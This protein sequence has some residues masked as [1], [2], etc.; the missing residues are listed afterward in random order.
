MIS[1]EA[2]RLYEQIEKPI[3][4]NRPLGLGFPSDV[5]QSSYYPGSYRLSQ[6]ELMDISRLMEE[7]S[8]YP[9]NT[10][11]Y[12]HKVENGTVY[13]ILQAST[14]EDPEPPILQDAKHSVTRLVRGDHKT[15]LTSVCNSLNDARKHAANT[16]Q[17]SF[18]LSCQESFRTGSIED[19]RESQR[20]WVKDLQPSVEAILG[21][22]EPYRDP[23]GIR[24]EFEGMV[25]IT[26]KEET[27]TLTKLVGNS[28]KFI[29]R[30]P[31]ALGYT[32]NNG[33]GPFE[34]ELFEKP[35]FTSLHSKPSA[36]GSCPCLTICSASLQFEYHFSWY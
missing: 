4:A 21:F 27:K 25:A 26:N 20:L 15:E 14:Q 17:D 19:Y 22:V 34:K 12:K 9:E 1:G 11:V 32:E 29:R 5:A 30:L 24:A 28:D 18:L 2:S 36:Q 8:I 16:R 7:K 6:E 33:K 31:W 10:R 13:D 35:D 3:L 23:M